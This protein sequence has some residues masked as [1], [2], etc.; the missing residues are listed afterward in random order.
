MT[1]RPCKVSSKG[2]HTWTS[3]ELEQ[4]E[5]RHPIGTK[6]RLAFGLLIYT[7]VRRSD[8]VRLGRQ[9]VR[10]GWLKFYRLQGP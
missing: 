4:F 2:H 5:A 6:A 7:G 8:V 3:E 1:K 9:H 10:D